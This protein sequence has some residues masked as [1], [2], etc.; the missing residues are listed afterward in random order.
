MAFQI[1]LR[2]RGSQPQCSTHATDIKARRLQCTGSWHPLQ[3]L[4]TYFE[5]KFTQV[6]RRLC[7]WQS[8]RLHQ[9]ALN[10]Q[11]AASLKSPLQRVKCLEEVQARDADLPTTIRRVTAAATSS[12]KLP[13]LKVANHARLQSKGTIRKTRGTRSLGPTRSPFGNF[14]VVA[15][16][17][18]LYG[19]SDKRRRESLC[20]PRT[21][22]IHPSTAPADY[23]LIPAKDGPLET[24]T[25]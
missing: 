9:N 8:L 17:C 2:F 12:T 14:D 6:N 15:N 23:V 10:L 21:S 16:F 3:R 18:C 19:G 4:W 13:S 22:V 20:E 7:H 11:L 25:E 24:V 1:I 5:R